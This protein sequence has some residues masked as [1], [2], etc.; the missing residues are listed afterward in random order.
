M[1]WNEG[2]VVDVDYTTSFFSDLSPAYLNFAAI[3]NGCEPVPVDRPFN[4]CELGCG[5]GFTVSVLAAAYPQ[6]EFF[7][8]DFMPSQIATATQLAAS[9]QLNNLT[10]LENSFSDLVESKVPDLPQFDFITMYGVY[11]WVSAENR[12]HIVDFISRY[13]KPGGIVFVCYNAMPGWSSAMPLQKLLQQY[14]QTHPEHPNIQMLRGREFIQSLGDSQAQYWTANAANDKFKHCINSLAKDDPVYLTHEY[15]NQNWEPMYHA[16]VNSQMSAAKLDYVGSANLLL[17]FP[18][19]YLSAD[20]QRLLATIS[21]PV[22]KETVK[23]YLLN[24]SFRKDVFIRGARRMSKL[25]QLECMQQVGLALTVPRFKACADHGFMKGKE[26]QYTAIYDALANG[27]QLL[28]ELIKLPQLGNPSMQKMAEMASILISD[29]HVSA[30]FVGDTDI[31]AAHRLNHAV[32]QNSRFDDS[33]RALVSPLLGNG[34]LSGLVQRLVYLSLASGAD[35]HDV[36]EITEQVFQ[37]MKAQE[38]PDT[39]IDEAAEIKEKRKAELMETVKG[40]I[41]HRLPVWRQLKVL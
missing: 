2:Y 17:S 24:T 25:R 29:H 26:D 18:S 28:S 22:M 39:S 8:V 38:N 12:Q 14:A 34:L 20:K 23:D 9:A 10:L 15:L 27:P 36:D 4:Y 6:G 7:G 31:S 32:A 19:L 30:Y 21:S 13:L 3:L 33:Y 11:T 41:V 1:A 35:E 16:D 5:Q 37:I 40:I